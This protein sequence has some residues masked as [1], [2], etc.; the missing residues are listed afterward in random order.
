[1]ASSPLN[2]MHI[3]N[4]KLKTTNM[5]KILLS[6]AI[7]LCLQGLLA[8]TRIT[9]TVLSSADNSPLVGA[10]VRLKN[11]PLFTTTDGS[12]KFALAADTSSILVFSHIGYDTIELKP[13]NRNRLTVIL[14][15]SSVILAGVTIST[16]YQQISGERT[17]GAFDKI[18]A[19][20]LD[21]V[22]ST[23]IIPKLEGLTPG[24]YLSKLNGKTEL[25]VRGLSTLLAETQPLIVLDNFPYE[26]NLADINPNDVESITI[27]KDASAASIWGARAGNG[28]IVITTK[29]GT[30]QQPQRITVTANLTVQDRPDAF[31]DPAF[32]NSPGFIEV[33]KFLF[34]KGFYNAALSNTFNRPVI[35]PVVEILAKQK[36][37]QLSAADAAA[38]IE[39]L[40]KFDVRNDMQRYLYR[41]LV[42]QQYA[43]SVSGGTA[44]ANYLF[45]LGFD[46]TLANALG[47][48]QQRQTISSIINFR[49]FPALE[50]GTALYYTTNKNHN[51]S[52]TDLA[53][54]GGKS[55]IYPYAR[56]AD[57][58]G[59]PLPLDKFY[60]MSF[61]DTAGA[62]L[63]LDWK[64]RPLEEAKLRSYTTTSQH[65]LARLSATYRFAPSLN[66]EFKYQWEQSSEELHNYT[67]VESFFARDLINL[68]SQRSGTGIIRNLPYGGFL[69][70]TR[71]QLLAQGLRAQ[72]NYNATF[73]QVHRFSALLGAEARSSNTRSQSG[74]TYGYDD[75]MTT[76]A[77]V[78]YLTAF[79][80][81]GNIGINTIPY[82]TD[83]AG[84]TNRFLSL[85]SNASYTLRSRYVVSTSAR[86]DASNIFGVNT[87]NKWQ[88]LWSLG[89][90]WKLSEEPFYHLHWLPQLKL[91]SSWGY[92]GNVVPLS[93]L[94]T[95][96]YNA[97]PQ[98]VT[99]LTFA[100]VASP[101]NPDLRWEKVGMWN[102]GLDFAIKN[103]RIRGSFDYYRKNSTDLLGTTAVDPTT[104]VSNMTK[105]TANLRGQGIDLNLEAVIVNRKMN[106]RT[107]LL[108]SYV[109]NKITRYY[110]ASNSV[111]NIVGNGNLISP[112]EGQKPYFLA[113]F[114]WAGLDPLTG[115]PLRYY[116]GAVSKD[117]ASIV[118]KAT[119][120][121]LA[122][123]GTTRPPFF[124]NW[125]NSFSC[126]GFT[127]TAGIR[128]RFH[129]WFRRSALS[130]S[131]L[132]NYWQGNEEFARRWQKPGDEKFTNVPS[133]VYPAIS[134]RDQFYVLSGA[135]VE[136]GDF[137]RLQDVSLGYNLTSLRLGKSEIPSAQV[138]VYATNC[139]LLW[140]AN[141]QHLDPEYGTATPPS[142][143]VSL[144][145]KTNF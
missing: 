3:P 101:P 95:I 45:S 33:E 38:Q 78:D 20:S 36:S 132:F 55:S 103:N 28:V 127:L 142:L 72:L 105:N 120:N 107:Q 29:K 115:D 61:V 19:T 121:D 141:K 126:G 63:L 88:P 43:A 133:M 41:R 97:R 113:S 130:Y 145:V 26:G 128:Y 13:G 56:L 27:L 74:R 98:S 110:A 75:D 54:A 50:I 116:Q 86:K 139:G 34:D 1:M 68:Y 6:L 65:I 123:H 4:Q 76:F 30:Y 62:G 48:D 109:T 106:W 77:N 129:Y 131:S 15:L 53:P 49:P 84:Q 87:N 82:L 92:S 111:F 117:Y 47:D 58:N 16:G 25:A 42:R 23:N 21:R 59:N 99:N 17:T 140:R 124:G 108:F 11:T 114:K 135:T 12:G 138:F 32:L 2:D 102:A 118:N 143:S 81:W 70:Q 8:Q 52:Y 51:N 46:K 57:D 22:V 100:S 37:G 96:R 5:K 104:G 93:A 31:Y 40:S 14:Q 35:S 94:A 91:R 83:F 7:L 10:T 69:E 71:S 80:L 24:L 64:L 144:G 44:S 89:A 90:A 112:V 67:P 60:R 39:A 134:A 122:F 18:T 73:N 136:R 137:I 66:A 125:I 85:Y 79:T 119:L 9:G